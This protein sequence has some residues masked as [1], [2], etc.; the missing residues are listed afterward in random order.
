MV[1]ESENE[2]SGIGNY[3]IKPNV[4]PEKNIHTFTVES[5][6]GAETTTKSGRLATKIS[7][8]TFNF[9]TDPSGDVIMVE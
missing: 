4:N 3:T 8:L 6:Q 9:K 5:R 2:F 1:E 7:Y